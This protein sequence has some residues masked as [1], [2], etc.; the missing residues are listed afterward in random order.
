M[1]IYAA[2]IQINVKNKSDLKKLE[3]RF[4][5]INDAAVS[6]NKTLKGLGRRNAIRVDTRAAM[7][8][9]SSLEARIRGLNQTIRVDARTSGRGRDNVGGVGAA[10]PLAAGLFGKRRQQQ[11]VSTRD[12]FDLGQGVFR[13][14]IK[15]LGKDIK[16]QQS[17]VE[18]FG[19]T[20]RRSQEKY[21]KAIEKV[22]DHQAVSKK[23]LGE[24]DKAI[25]NQPWAK[26]TKG[27]LP[28][29]SGDNLLKF[30][31]AYL[32]TNSKI[33][34]KITNTNKELVDQATHQKKINEVAQ[35]NLRDQEDKLDFR[36]QILKATQE[37]QDQTIRRAL[38][39][40]REI[41]LHKQINQE[42]VKG[43]KAFRQQLE[44]QKKINGELVAGRQPAQT[45]T[46]QFEAAKK[47][48]KDAFNNVLRLKR[49]LANPAPKGGLLTQMGASFKGLGKKGAMGAA[50]RGALASGALIPGISPLAVGGF[51]GASGGGGMAGGLIG[52]GIAGLVQL[53]VATAG[54]ARQAALAQAE[55][56]KMQV[57][58]KGVTPDYDSYIQALTNVEKLSDKFAISQKD[59]IKNFTKLQAS[60]SA[61][62]FTVEQVTEAYEGLA[63]GTL[64]TGGNQ[65]KLN[66]I[67]LAASQIFAKGKVAAEEIRGQISER[68]PGTMAIFAESMGITGKALDKL[69]QEGKVT[70]EDFLKFTQFLGKVHGK[71]AAEMVKDSSNA[72]Q[73]LA[74]EWDDL[75][76]NMGVIIQP[77]GAKMQEMLAGILKQIN[78]VSGG[79]IKVLGMTEKARAENRKT[80]RE[81]LEEQIT[82]ATETVKL[83]KPNNF[84]RNIF[85][86]L[87]N[88]G[89]SGGQFSLNPT[90][91]EFQINESQDLIKR[92][93]LPGKSMGPGSLSAT[94]IR[95]NELL[96]DYKLLIA[97][98]AR[99]N[100]LKK[101]GNA[102]DK[103]GKELDP[104]REAQWKKI[105]DQL[106][107]DIQ[108]QKDKIR[109]GEREAEIQ[110]QLT[111]LKLQF[112]EKNADEI[113][114][115]LRQ[116]DE[117][118]NKTL[119][120]K[121]A[122]T[123]LG[124]E[125]SQRIEEV[126]S[127]LKQLREITETFRDSFS[128]T[129]RDIV[130]GTKGIGDAVA[131]MLNR[132]AD[133][134]IQNAADMVA[135]S[136]TKG[137]TSFLGN[138]LSSIF[139]PG[140]GL[141]KAVDFTPGGTASFGFSNAPSMGYASGGYVD[142]P[143]KALIGEGSE[144]EYVIPESKLNESLSRYQAGH[145]GSSVV[146]GGV[147]G[148]GNSAGGSG[149]VTVNYT[150]PTLNFNGDEYVPRSAVPQII[151]SAAKAGASAG[152]SKTFNELK[153]SR[154]QR[155]RL[156]L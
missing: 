135:A 25:K 11:K 56:K 57:A 92:G 36:K 84:L 155:A 88:L 153:N 76:I 40:D 42:K 53:G 47:A 132:I 69:L 147:G 128:D 28:K 10:L 86:G 93:G 123:V 63:A 22:N 62:G 39:S 32:R 109:L 26:F 41:D 8:A 127:P 29:T 126:Y 58:V 35:A 156:G 152:A 52:V 50:G 5:Q 94:E 65:E 107:T 9:I 6:L 31:T 43:F 131:S 37:E 48:T 141:T 2:D 75:L 138:A 146:P 83:G 3:N 129:V 142:R 68:L 111:E 137:I 82:S 110:R 16:Q 19:E 124:R 59:T 154:S 102:I 89:A 95:K 44:H 34:D 99:L 55:F 122:F 90:I 136:A 13:D 70:M 15:D 106:E 91:S 116:L 103:K 134:F 120:L 14:H 145:R 150:G 74:K 23:Q 105:K 12:L 125:A 27:F 71:T 112:P 66:G 20:A 133:A 54:V 121:E 98:Q 45:L 101:E 17:I 139:S 151:N 21:A 51:A 144:G 61:S 46:K 143:T 114:R 24:L 4:K 118:T 117:V 77:V 72:G 119:T 130:N 67:M 97:E 64:A 1:A 30:A 85:G 113:E 38:M 49:E 81:Q 33:N 104:K 100:E 18:N 87:K 149:E 78:E 96:R 115:L 73:R 108:F 148:T 80:K 60:A 79:F 7:T 140:K